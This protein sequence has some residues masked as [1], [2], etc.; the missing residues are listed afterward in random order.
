MSYSQIKEIGICN[1]V[2]IGVPQLPCCAKKLNVIPKSIKIGSN[3]SYCFIFLNFIGLLS[4][5]YFFLES[6]FYNR[7]KLYHC[8]RG[9][10]RIGF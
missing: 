7:I 10:R 9:N 1:R 5:S 4:A 8:L 3:F 2:G 6:K